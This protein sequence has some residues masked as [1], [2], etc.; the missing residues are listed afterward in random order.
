MYG[1]AARASSA[2]LQNGLGAGGDHKFP[3][4]KDVACG[5]ARIGIQLTDGHPC[6][7]APILTSAVSVPCPQA[8]PC[9]MSPSRMLVSFA[10]SKR[11]R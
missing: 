4:L 2:A 6:P 11:S 3:E 10:S 8:I 9:G 1:R 5:L 7:E